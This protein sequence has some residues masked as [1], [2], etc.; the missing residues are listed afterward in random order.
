MERKFLKIW[1]YLT[2]LS[3]FLENAL[4]FA[5]V[6]YCKFHDCA[7]FW[8]NGKHFKIVVT[9]LSVYKYSGTLI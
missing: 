5:T 9:N 3:S 2:K 7:F 8:L 1:A 4:S 6:Y